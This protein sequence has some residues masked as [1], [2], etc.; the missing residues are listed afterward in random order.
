MM[1][2]REK[3]KWVAIDASAQAFPTVWRELKKVYSFDTLIPLFT[4]GMFDRVLKTCF[5]SSYF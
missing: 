4:K 5:P 1:Q 3:E 2:E